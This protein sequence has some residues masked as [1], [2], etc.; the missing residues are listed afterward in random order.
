M[1]WFKKQSKLVQVLLVLIP[2]VNWIVELVLRWDMFLKKG[3]VVRLV[4]AIV[5]TF[6]GLVVGWL[7]ALWLLLFDKIFLQ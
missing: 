1:D 3:G 6:G 7:D 4:I 2:F 5:V